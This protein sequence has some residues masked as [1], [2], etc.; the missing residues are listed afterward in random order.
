MALR[1]IRQQGDDILH[2]K[3]KPVK[4]INAGTLQ[5]LDDM[6]ETMDAN[7]GLGLAAPQVGVLRRIVVIRVEDALFELI[8]PEIIETEGEQRRNEGCLSVPGKSG[9]VIRPQRVAVKALNR[10]GETVTVEGTELLAVA[11]CHELDHLEGVLFTDK[12]L[13]V[14]DVTAEEEEDEDSAEKA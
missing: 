3:A 4:E 8:N 7:D 2:K 14:H 9:T 1:K 11:F 6:L 12:A 13:E 10:Q 5:L